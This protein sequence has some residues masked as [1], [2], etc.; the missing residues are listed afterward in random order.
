M[1]TG[2]GIQV[3][4]G[5][6]PQVSVLLIGGIYEVRLEVALGGM[7]YIR[8]FMTNGSGIQVT[9][10]ALPQQFERLLCWKY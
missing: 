2:P 1:T 8:R 4:L 5:L 9:I 10:R 7:R 3:V 6:L